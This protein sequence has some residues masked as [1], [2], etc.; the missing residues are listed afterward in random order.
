MTTA[1]YHICNLPSDKYYSDFD[2]LSKKENLKS[3]CDSND[4]INSGKNEVSVE[5]LLSKYD[6]LKDFCYKLE[7]NLLHLKDNKD[8]SDELKK[9]CTFMQL[10]IQDKVINTVESKSMLLYFTIFYKIWGDIMD[11]TEIKNNNIC[12][13]NHYPISIHDYTKWKKMHDYNYNYKNVQCSLKNHQGC[14]EDC[15]E[16]CRKNCKEYYCTYILDI[17]NI[18]NEFEHVCDSATNK[19]RCPEYWNNFKINY[20]LNSEIELLCK[21]VYNKLGFY[22]V[23]MYFEEEGIE[24]YIDQYET[25]HTFS[26][27]EKIVGYSLSLFGSKIAPKADDMR[28]MWRN[29]Q[30]V[31]NPASLLNPMKPPGGGNKM[32]LSYLPK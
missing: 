16:E 7:A 6:G 1:D 25:Q 24:K 31:T 11:N 15:N 2:K 23:K 17:V 21:E 28:K 10:L 26:F 27:L 8:S 14:N 9:R 12:K 13:P 22:K 30:G 29:V 5:N 4:N 20:S 19:Q 18:Y 3:F 32:G